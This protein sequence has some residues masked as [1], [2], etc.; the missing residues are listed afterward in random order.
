[1]PRTSLRIVLTRHFLRLTVKTGCKTEFQSILI[2][3][4]PLQ[5]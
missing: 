4:T 1:M 5:V 3:F 2:D